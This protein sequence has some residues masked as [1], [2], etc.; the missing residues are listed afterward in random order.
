MLG[1]VD[2]RTG[3]SGATAEAG[4]AV[5]AARRRAQAGDRASVRQAWLDAGEQAREAGAFDLLTECALEVSPSAAFLDDD[6]EVRALVATARAHATGD[7][8]LRLDARFVRLLP[9]RD[10]ELRQELARNVVAATAH[11][12][13]PRLTIEAELSY[14]DAFWRPEHLDERLA[15]ADRAVA[16]AL[17][18]GLLDL[19]LDAR[20]WRFIMLLEA[21][22]V[23]DAAEEVRCCEALAAV[24]G[25][26]E[27]LLQARVRGACLA[28][29]E[30]RYDDAE[31]LI[32]EVA[33]LASQ[34]ESPDR[35][36]VEDTQRAVLAFHTGDRAGIEASLSPVARQR[37]PHALV[38]GLAAL[39]GRRDLARE[40]LAIG[41][42]EL[43]EASGPRASA[44]LALA[45]IAADDLGD[46]EAGQVLVDRLEPLRGGIAV[47]AGGVGAIGPIDHFLA[48]AA[49]AAGD[50]DAARAAAEAS[51]ALSQRIGAPTWAARSARVVNELA[52]PS[53]G[54]GAARVDVDIPVA[55]RHGRTGWSV[56]VEEEWQALGDK[57]G[58]GQLAVLLANPGQRVHVSRL[59][60]V[61]TGAGAAPVLDAAAIGRY[62][63]RLAELDSAE[64]DADRRGDAAAS[65]RLAGERQALERELRSARGLHGRGRPL[66]SDVERVRVNVTRTIRHAIAD[67]A[68]HAPAAAAHL[69]A[70]VHTGTFC[71]YDPDPGV[72]ATS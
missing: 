47:V 22:R 24:W 57:K 43:W 28:I 60:D 69:D 11:G 63:A 34:A 71:S 65:A 51:V 19:E 38:A 18:H 54:S 17:V 7:D 10:R 44:M 15:H 48:L 4:A 39:I 55:L 72:G 45:S 70:T 64:D 1:A 25:R 31:R 61:P 37:L 2:A 53:G 26:P 9:S 14:L 42:R 6:A 5:A 12:C 8:R 35:Q 56:L 36:L 16:L 30:D 59:A 29:L 40:E 49:R 62:R 33:D 23:A 66:G 32:G 21:A 13:E 27:G 46:R 58:Y 50:P 20:L 67:L 52:S 41:V 68:V 3:D